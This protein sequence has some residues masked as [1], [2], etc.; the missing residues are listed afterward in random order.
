MS[1]DVPKIDTGISPETTATAHHDSIAHTLKTSDGISGALA[2][3]K[4][5]NERATIEP[6]SESSFQKLKDLNQKRWSL[7]SGREWEEKQK[8]VQTV[9]DLED[10]IEYGEQALVELDANV[11]EQDQDGTD[12]EKQFN[13]AHAAAAEAYKNSATRGKLQY[14]ERSDILEPGGDIFPESK[15]SIPDLTKTARERRTLL[16]GALPK[17]KKWLEQARKAGESEKQD[18]ENSALADV[19]KKTD[20]LSE[21]ISQAATEAAVI[22]DALTQNKIDEEYFQEAGVHNYSGGAD[23]STRTWN[24]AVKQ[25]PREI[26]GNKTIDSAGALIWQ[27]GKIV[28]LEKNAVVNAHQVGQMRQQLLDRKQEL[29]AELRS[30]HAEA[31]TA[32]EKASSLGAHIDTGKESAFLSGNPHAAVLA[33]L[34]KI[35]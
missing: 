32:L 20:E 27:Q 12:F 22:Q 14:D 19:R 3:L 34:E 2:R 15:I 10:L 1:H 31:T 24:A 8:A 29:A 7:G 23:Y 25:T 33:Q 6:S 35:V 5:A 28:G 13:A 11:N 4:S 21:F 30:K 9:A 18:R 26:I 17:A 16:Q